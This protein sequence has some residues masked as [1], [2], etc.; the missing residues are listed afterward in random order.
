[1]KYATWKLNFTDPNYG[2]GPEES[3]VQQGGTVEASFAEGEVA[4]GARVLGY[5]SGNPTGLESWDFT[6][7]TQQEALEFVLAFDD[8]A[9][10]EEDGQINIS[11]PAEII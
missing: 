10:V 9:F 1:M 8:T 7:I 2:T 6:E 11:F 4:N 3:I 5:F